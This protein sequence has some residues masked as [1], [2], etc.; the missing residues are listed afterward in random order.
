MDDNE[1]G[2]NAESRPTCIRAQSPGREEHGSADASGGIEEG[3][4][5]DFSV[6]SSSRHCHPTAEGPFSLPPRSRLALRKGPPSL[7]ARR[8]L[9]EQQ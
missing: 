8:L 4:V 3:S 6:L 1:I 2:T 5:E 7:A 9:S